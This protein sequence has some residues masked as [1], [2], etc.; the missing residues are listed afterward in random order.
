MSGRLVRCVCALALVAATAAAAPAPPPGGSAERPG[1]RSV[2]AL[3]TRLRTLYRQAEAASK[4]YEAA[5]PELR[6]QR[7]LADRTAEELAVARTAL[8]DSRDEAGRLAREQYRDLGGSLSPAVT[9][10]LT[11]DPRAALLRRHEL[12]RAAA[13]RAAALSRLVASVA[14]AEGTARR[15]RSALDAQLTSATV[16]DRRR[17]AARRGLD[18]VERLLAGLTDAQLAALGRGERAPAPPL[19]RFPGAGPRT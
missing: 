13:G 4:E 9:F 11:A 8:A 10:L 3:L 18:E 15:A 5:A 6:R 14:R 17:E 7:A 19:H 1:D 2:G 12:G 16:R